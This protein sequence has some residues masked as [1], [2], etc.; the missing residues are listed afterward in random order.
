MSPKPPEREVKP[1]NPR[2]VTIG[3]TVQ[4]CSFQYQVLA[5]IKDDES[6]IF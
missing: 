5:D 6:F 4:G 1:I 2:R 3:I